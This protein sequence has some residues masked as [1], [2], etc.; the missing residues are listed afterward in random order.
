MPSLISRS[1][2]ASSWRS[3]LL[4]TFVR[5]TRVSSLFWLDLRS[6]TYS[7]C[8]KTV[9]A[10]LCLPVHAST[11]AATRPLSTSEPTKYKL[12]WFNLQ[13][14]SDK[15]VNSLIVRAV[16]GKCGLVNAC[17]LRH[18]RRMVCGN[19]VMWALLLRSS[20]CRKV[21]SIQIQIKMIQNLKF[22]ACLCVRDR[23]SREMSICALCV[24]QQPF[25]SDFYNN[26]T[27]TD[28]SMRKSLKL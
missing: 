16:L 2:P 1:S 6:R 3:N 14:T 13:L 28:I 4:D 7:K 26:S 12:P 15:V 8:N 10:T 5:R 23:G 22:K 18:G 11:T 25:R 9:S 17:N 21:S 19:A 20:R 27:G 24:R